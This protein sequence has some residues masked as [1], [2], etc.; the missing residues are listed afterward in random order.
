M[1]KTVQSKKEK[2]KEK[3]NREKKERDQTFVI[4][5]PFSL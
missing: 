1:F 5:S 2:K 4:S 3:K